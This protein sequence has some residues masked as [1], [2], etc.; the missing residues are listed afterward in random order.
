MKLTDFFFYRFIFLSGSLVE[1]GQFCILYWVHSVWKL[2]NLKCPNSRVWLTLASQEVSLEIFLMWPSPSDVQ[3]S[4]KTMVLYPLLNCDVQSQGRTPR[5]PSLCR[6]TW[7]FI[8]QCDLGPS[9]SRG[10]AQSQCAIELRWH[11]GLEEVAIYKVY[12]NVQTKLRLEQNCHPSV[13]WG[14]KIRTESWPSTM[15]RCD[16]YTKKW[17]CRKRVQD[18]KHQLSNRLAAMKS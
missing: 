2:C 18:S 12:N 16:L 13:V 9:R 1:A 8:C 4:G 5:E 17:S 6:G 11:L 14:G 15:P 7:S 3:L 10:Q